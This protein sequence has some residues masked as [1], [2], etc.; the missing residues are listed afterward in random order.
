MSTYL[1]IDIGTGNV[2]VALAGID[3]HILWVGRDDVIYKKDGQYKEGL[4]FEPDI[5]WQQILKLI[6][7]ALTANK[8]VKIVAITVSSQR[9]GIVLLDKAGEP[10]IGFPNHDHRGRLMEDTI[11][12]KDAVYRLTGRYPTSLFSALKLTAYREKYPE[13]WKQV[14]CFLSISDWAQYMLSGVKG[15]EHAQAS[16]TLLYD[17]KNKCWS[18]QLFAV[19]DLDEGLVPPLYFSGKEVGS[20]KKEYSLQWSLDPAVPVLVGGADTQLAIKSTRPQTGDVVIVSG[21]TTPVVNVT[22]DYILDKKQ[23]SWTN[24]HLGKKQYILE[25]NCG[26]TGLNYHHIKDIFYP[27][28]SYET[29]EKELDNINKASCFAHLGSLIADDKEVVTR[30]GF[31]FEVP[32][33]TEMSRAD[34]AFAALWDIACSIKENFECL[35]DIQH[36]DNDYV[37]C[38]GGGFQSRHLREYIAGLTGK[39]LLVRPGYQQASVSGAA[40]VCSEALGNHE[41]MD[42][43][44]ETVLPE[45]SEQYNL[46][47][48]EWKKTRNHLKNYHNDFGSA[49]V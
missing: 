18:D 16:E 33:M 12:D 30:G 49:P 22:S 17:V 40:V 25:T 39:K 36:S 46:W 47:Y 19:F 24:S 29:I 37:W 45:K 43:S 34:F 2:R 4:Y 42:S 35:L 48:K 15:Y 38:C 26:V 23:R 13:E 6:N 32:I 44:V 31:I 10:M 9:E 27:N 21:T 8:E 5:L 3:G 1:I 7:S 14:N 11:K 41:K 20:I 28:E